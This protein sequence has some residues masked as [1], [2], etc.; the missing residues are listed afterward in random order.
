[1][2]LEYQS[3]YFETILEIAINIRNEETSLYASFWK[4][5]QKYQTPRPARVRKITNVAVPKKTFRKSP[6]SPER[7][8]GRV[9]DG[10]ISVRMDCMVNVFCFISRGKTKK[11]L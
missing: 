2:N 9:R 4:S 6:K 8:T 11:D 5:V 3:A 1:M 10:V 7:E